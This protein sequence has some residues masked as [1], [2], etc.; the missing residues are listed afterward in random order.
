M[1][2]K[3]IFHPDTHL[4]IDAALTWY[5]SINTTL[6]IE[7]EAELIKCYQKIGNNPQ[8][9]FILH[10]RLKIRRALLKKFTYKLVFQIQKNKTVWI[11]ALAHQRQKSYWKR[12]L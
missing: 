12:R 9:Y 1:P 11:I 5:E 3:I 6:S 8:H 10:K 2:Y 4:E 7:L